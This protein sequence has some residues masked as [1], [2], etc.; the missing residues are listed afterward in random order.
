MK[1]D[2][3]LPNTLIIGIQAGINKSTLISYIKSLA[4]TSFINTNS[5]AYS[6]M[7]LEENKFL[8]EIHDGSKQLTYLKLIK[9]EL[10]DNDE[11]EIIL[12]TNKDNIR[13]EKLSE[14]RI[15]TTILIG[16]K[17]VICETFIDLNTKGSLTPLV[18]N[19]KKLL[20]ISLT[21]LL[22]SGLTA[23]FSYYT[24][25]SMLNKDYSFVA[26]QDKSLSPL[27][28]VKQINFTDHS[29][30]KYINN[31]AFDGKKWNVNYADLDI[32]NIDGIS[33]LKKKEIV[34]DITKKRN[35]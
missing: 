30:S 34:N 32:K 28:F 13:V 22:V 20:T 23:S 25:Y 5:V 3:Y 18:K 27:S 8:F 35:K 4:N 1:N 21:L 10:F 15:E 19:N 31:I 29:E 17:N 6:I 26:M 33:K 16:S 12:K 14:N 9:S 11:T 2:K 24:K 7:K